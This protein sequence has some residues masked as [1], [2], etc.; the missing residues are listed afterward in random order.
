MA[1]QQLKD[2]INSPWASSFSWNAKDGA[3]SQVQGLTLGAKLIFVFSVTFGIIG[4]W[5][6]FVVIELFE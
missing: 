1:R 6:W 5:S 2:A 3:D 4:L